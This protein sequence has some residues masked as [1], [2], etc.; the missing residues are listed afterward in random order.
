[1]CIRR[2]KNGKYVYDGT[3][4]SVCTIDVD[5]WI[6]F[7]THD[8]ESEENTKRKQHNNTRHATHI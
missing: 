1:M 7:M 2:I 8:Q 6:T 5:E 3:G 4:A